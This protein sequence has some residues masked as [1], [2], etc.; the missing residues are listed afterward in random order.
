MLDF[1]NLLFHLHVCSYR[2]VKSTV[3]SPLFFFTSFDFYELQSITFC[4]HTTNYSISV[5]TLCSCVV[6]MCCG[7]YLRPSSFDNAKKEYSYT[8]TYNHFEHNQ[9]GVLEPRPG[10][11]MRVRVAIFS[12]GG[13][14][15]CSQTPYN[16]CAV[17]KSP[18]PQQKMLYED[19]S[20]ELHH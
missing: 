8:K 13:R 3:K 16:R 11:C 15:A 9:L 6:F 10:C 2:Y 18:T 20:T 17:Y 12:R 7:L 19:L 5:S 14:E 4:R 1:C